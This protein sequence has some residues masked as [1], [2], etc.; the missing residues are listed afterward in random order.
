MWHKQLQISPGLLGAALAVMPIALIVAMQ[1]SHSATLASGSGLELVLLGLIFVACFAVMAVFVLSLT[2]FV[3]DDATAVAKA[4]LQVAEGAWLLLLLRLL[5]Q[6][7]LR[8]LLLYRLIKFVTDTLLDPVRD[9]RL[10]PEIGPI[11]HEPR[12][13]SYP[14]TLP[15]PSASWPKGN[16]THVRYH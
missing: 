13:S 16:P 5:L 15:R 2:A 14:E 12:L 6:L 9:N 7:L 4:S 3:L 8:L 11:L 10:R 1:A